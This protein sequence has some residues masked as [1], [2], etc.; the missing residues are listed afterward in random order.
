[1]S[2][3]LLVIASSSVLPV[4]N[5][6]V[7]ITPYPPCRHPCNA[8]LLYTCTEPP[9]PTDYSITLHLISLPSFATFSTVLCPATGSLFGE[10]HSR[11]ALLARL[12][13]CVMLLERAQ[14]RSQAL[15]APWVYWGSERGSVLY[16]AVSLCLCASAASHQLQLDIRGGCSSWHLT[17]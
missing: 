11:A 9:P 5:K 16:P 15:P 7:F 17:T 14:G 10:G 1:M 3:P 4:N 8:S 6:L 2:H 13:L 12:P